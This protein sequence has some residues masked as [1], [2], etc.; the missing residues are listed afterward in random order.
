MLK[1][2][3]TAKGGDKNGWEEEL[4]WLWVHSCAA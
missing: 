3:T 2:L 1:C 4:L